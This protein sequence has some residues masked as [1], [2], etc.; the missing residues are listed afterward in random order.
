MNFDYPYYHINYLDFNAY[1]TET[2]SLLKIQGLDDF[3]SR[4]LRNVFYFFQ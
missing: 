1:T 3:L 4:I 2:Q